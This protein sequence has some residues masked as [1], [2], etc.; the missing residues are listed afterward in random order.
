MGGGGRPAVLRAEQASTQDTLV[1]M[2]VPEC[3]LLVA[4][5]RA[6]RVVD[7]EHLQLAR[8]HG[9]AELIKQSRRQAR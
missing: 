7:V 4:M 3:K 2:R 5:R 1:V 6:E 9:R 8:L